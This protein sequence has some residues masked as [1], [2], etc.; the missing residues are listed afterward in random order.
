MEHIKLVDSCMAISN[1][2]K[3]KNN[4]ANLTCWVTNKVCF[5]IH[6]TLS[7]LT[8]SRN[9]GMLLFLKMSRLQWFTLNNTKN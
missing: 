4:M 9:P 5:N 8:R 3:E 6:R 2:G 1:M 7:V